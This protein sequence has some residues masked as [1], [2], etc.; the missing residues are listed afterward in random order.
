MKIV[1]V[2]IGKLGEHL[3]RLLVK[4]NNDVTLI[5]KNFEGKEA[6]INNEDV[7]YVEGNALDSLTLTEAG[8]AESDLL[9]SVMKDDAQNLMCSLLGKNLGAKH[10]IA[11]VR[12]PEYT[13]SINIIKDTLGLS[14]A[15]NPELLAASQIAQ[16][17]SIPSALDATSFLKGKV[18]VVSLKVK[19]DSKLKNTTISHLAK[20]IGDSV[21]ICAIERES[22]VIIPSGNTKIEIGDIIHV[23]GTRK[24]INNFLKYT[25]SIADKTK[26][27][28]IAGGSRTSI[29]LTRMLLDMGMSVT[30]IEND[31][32]RCK[33]IS[34]KIP[35]ALLIKADVS[36][37]N[38]LYEEGIKYCD[39]FVSLTNIDE[40]NIVYSMFASIVGVPKIITKINHIELDGVM[41]KASIDTSIAP[42]K[43]AANHV[44]QYVRAMEHSGASSCE[45]VYSF[46]DDIFEMIEFKVK[47]DFKGINKRLMDLNFRENVIIGAIQRGKNIIYPSG[48]D[49]IKLNDTIVIVSKSN[50]IRELNDVVR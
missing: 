23:T 41:Q 8:I 46:G 26:R 13:N 45:A 4:E 16:T 35:K 7:N 49:E 40:E 33:E 50:L 48:K 18:D 14:M 24:D 19:E 30:I 37:Q 42:H 11:R 9:I 34:E 32:E 36:D 3:A 5:D 44:V 12:N 38:V 31:E 25:G 17:L 10:T 21:I 39:A 6:I 1:I 29:Y 43:I 28:I 20:K 2:G 47:E 22:E 27:V 15:I